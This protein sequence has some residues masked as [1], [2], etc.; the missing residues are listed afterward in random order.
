MNPFKHNPNPT[1]RATAMCGFVLAGSLLLAACGQSDARSAANNA[2]AQTENIASATTAPARA[3]ATA[4]VAA[5]QS[6]TKAPTHQTATDATSDRATEI[7]ITLNGTAINANHPSVTVSEGRALITA[8]GTYRLSGTLAD[9]QIAIKTADKDAVR[10]ILDGV[11]MSNSKGAAIAFEEVEKAVIVL[12]DNTQN[13]VTDGASYVFPDS[14]IDEPNA[15]IFSKSDLT[16]D[17]GGALTV[18]ANFNDGIASKDGLVIA[19]GDITVNA[20]DDGI[21]GKDYLVIHGGTFNITSKGDGLKADNGEDAALGYIAIDNG[22]IAIA[23]GG[24]AIQAQ[25]DL[26]IKAGL[27]KLVAGGGSAVRPT[28]G[29]STKGLKASAKLIVDGGEFVVDASD[30][31]VHTNQAMT[32]NGGQFHLASGDDAMHADVSLQINGGKV[33]VTQSYEA[34][35]SSVITINNGEIDVTSDDDAI[36]VADKTGTGVPVPRGRRGQEVTTYTGSNFLY[37]NGGRILV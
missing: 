13:T 11:N 14:A 30:D 21:R 18:Q 5:P 1:R 23:A 17:G 27:F 9:G 16:I 25:T 37:V 36:N 33:R 26:L 31:A 20:A 7:P 4:A 3:A 6:A 15:A 35:E 2:P 24:D 8:A 34:I 22:T 12:A 10:L 32:I 28:E 19:R 29:K